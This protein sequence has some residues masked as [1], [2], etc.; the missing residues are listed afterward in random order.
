TR[1]T[2]ALNVRSGLAGQVVGIP[3]LRCLVPDEAQNAP[4][5]VSNDGFQRCSPSQL[6][7]GALHPEQKLVDIGPSRL[8]DYLTEDVCGCLGAFVALYLPP[9][10]EAVCNLG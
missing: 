8:G 4:Y 9:L 7:P 6:S 1:R 10:K 3:L 2:Q 5:N